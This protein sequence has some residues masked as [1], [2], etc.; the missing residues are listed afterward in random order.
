MKTIFKK[1]CKKGI[2]LIIATVILSSC[3]SDK[4]IM[5]FV[6]IDDVLAYS[7]FINI[8]NVQV[9]TFDEVNAFDLMNS[10]HWVVL[11]KDIPLF[12]EMVSKWL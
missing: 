4:K 5:L 10:N 3:I 2:T 9:V 8:P 1:G 12:K 11:E 6:S 7:S